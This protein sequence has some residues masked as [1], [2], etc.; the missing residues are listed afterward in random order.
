MGPLPAHNFFADSTVFHFPF[1]S[2]YGK[3]KY[4]V[5]TDIDP[6][7]EK[8]SEP[9]KK[10]IISLCLCAL[11]LVTLSS[12]PALAVDTFTASEACIALIK[13]YEGFRSQPYE[14]NG[15][16][17]IGY[18]TG[19]DDPAVYLYGITEEAAD[20]MLRQ[21][22]VDKEASV[23][24]LLM[25]YGI[26]VTQYQFDA[27]VSM[28]YNLGTQWMRP[29]YRFCS[30]LIQGIQNYTEAEVVNAI[31]TWCHQGTAV[32]D[33]LAQRRLREASLFLYG[34]YTGMLVS[35][36]CYIHFDAQG[37][38]LENS[39][40]FYPVG[41]PYGVLPTP[42]QAGRQFL[43]WFDS[44]G[45]QYTGAE[46][47]SGTNLT[48]TARWD[49]EAA[50]QPPAIDYSTWVNPFSDVTEESWFFESVREL[51]YKGIMNGYPDGT[52][53][54]DRDLT[55]GEALKL[56]LPAAGHADPGQVTPD[57]HWAG[58]LLAEAERLG[59][60]AYG[61]I[62]DLD[63]PITRSMVARIAAV[64]LGLDYRYGASPFADADDGYLLAL[65]EE[66]ILNGTVSGGQ[67]YFYPQNT[68][69]RS[70]VAAIVS[71]INNWERQV[72]NDPAQSGYIEYSNRFIPVKRDVPAAPYNNDL[73]VKDGSLMYYNDPAY[74]TAIGI[75]VSSYQG[76]IDWQK[77]AAAGV[78]FAFIRLGGRGY[79]EGAIFED[80]KFL[81]NVTGAKAAGIKVGVY[82]FSQA[83]SVEEAQE[84]ARFVLDKL[85]VNQISLDYPVVY[86]WEIV[87]SKTARTANMDP[88]VLTDCALAFCQAV[89]AEWFTPMIYCGREVA[90]TMYDLSRLTDY[91]LWYPQYASQPS[92][93]Y[94]YRIWQYTD[95]GSVP[96]ISGKVDMDLAFI[97]Y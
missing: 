86:D 46:M 29:D 27:M 73:F 22:L 21:A 12:P 72:E 11:I 80:Q 63:A 10:K 58:G 65:Y 14:D 38:E 78:Q 25:D 48:L 28:T 35:R 47:A 53:Q 41:L 67:R 36:Y 34:D 70:E 94:D 4:I 16:W 52:F 23:N 95:S 31:A 62:S 39:T 77:V 30:Y 55:C 51:S 87:S 85:I 57:G 19:I 32:K 42:V 74:Q 69:R 9:M 20:W 71:R 89:E 90:Y 2:S 97:P 66:G 5:S 24:R 56:I 81:Q 88:V 13:E 75:D 40:V 15:K 37:G 84:E 91:D 76:D 18:G 92:M 17:Y 59:C 6:T 68:I 45:Q 96:G 43:G 8:V 26:Y 61:E 83:V 7:L 54:P 49:G 1:L 79:S 44:F 3:L 93:Y 50:A 60:V 64:A 33:H 82:F